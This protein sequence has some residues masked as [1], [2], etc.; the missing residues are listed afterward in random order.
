MS[1][2]KCK[3]KVCSCIKN[4]VPKIAVNGIVQNQNENDVVNIKVPTKTSQLI[5]D[6]GFGQGNG[7]SSGGQKIENIRVNG[8]LVPIINKEAIMSVPTKTSDLI[9]NSNFVSKPYVDTH[10]VNKAN[11]HEVTKFQVGLGNVD[12]TSDLNKPIS[13]ATQTELNKKI[14]TTDIKSEVIYEDLKPV[15]SKA[16]EKYA[17]K[18]INT[19]ADLRNT[20]GD[21]E[22]QIV[23]LLGY[24]VKGDIEPL[25]YKWSNQQIVDNGGLEISSLNGSWSTIKNRL[26]VK[27]N[28]SALK[29]LPIS[30]IKLIEGGVYD[31]VEVLGY[32]KKGDTPKPI[33][34][35]L[36][37][38]SSIKDDTGYYIKPTLLANGI[39]KATE[40]INS[41]VWDIR[42]YSPLLYGKDTMRSIKDVFPNITQAD[43]NL[44]DSRGTVNNS[45]FWWWFTK[46]LYDAPI[47]ATI[48]LNGWY[49][50]DESILWKRCHTILEGVKRVD[51][52]PMD[53]DTGGLIEQTKEGADVITVIEG[54]G[55]TYHLPKYTVHNKLKNIT[56]LGGR[57]K[58][59]I[60]GSGLHFAHSN[61]GTS[62]DWNFDN[63]FFSNNNY[64]FLHSDGHI[65]SFSFN[66]CSFQGNIKSGFY[67]DGDSTKQLNA[68]V[69]NNGGASLNGFFKDVDGV[70]KQYIQDINN[71]DTSMNG[72]HIKGC[73]AINFIGFDFTLNSSYG[74]LLDDSYHLGV[75]VMCYAEKNSLADYRIRGNEEYNKE[76][77]VNT[78]SEGSKIIFDDL[79]VERKSRLNS[80]FNYVKGNVNK[81]ISNNII[82]S[83]MTNYEKTSDPVIYNENIINGCKEVEVKSETN[84][85]F[86]NYIK[87]TFTNGDLYIR[88]TFKKGDIIKFSLEFIFIS[89]SSENYFSVGVN[90]NDGGVY[91]NTK[92]NE[93]IKKTFIHEVT[94]ESIDYI[95]SILISGNAHV[96]YRK[97]YIEVISEN[98]IVVSD[99][100]IIATNTN[101][102]LVKK[103]VS[104]PDGSDINTL[105]T[106][107]RNAGIIDI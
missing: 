86:V 14:S 78:Y 90:L 16:V 61:G 20:N 105:L 101:F 55:R 27:N 103:G 82:N 42:Y 45:A 5:N 70:I 26:L 50:I 88:N 35:Y 71:P 59:V 63:V 33:V 7:G 40:M 28:I 79:N 15:N 93:W 58:N 99:P 66:K 89:S 95:F 107:L 38:D 22:G 3:C 62:I 57:D 44:I 54:D 47:N 75:G 17:V 23:E 13:T 19:I 32:T 67:S 25:N 65:N 31:G 85:S 72:I 97:P 48:I 41:N 53:F 18:K 1:C 46:V 91:Y 96:K 104:V 51:S 102:G 6:S 10:I 21:Y 76:V 39:F 74:L 69:F 60:T 8:E 4:D 43:I 83:L 11:P 64:G 87:P 2:K 49:K 98:P 34:Y 36:D 52:N 56:F 9:N 30:E 68:F 81:I 24:S 106:S 84:S 92:Q 37:S 73:T 94:D 29:S 77:F 80:L 12:N 100:S